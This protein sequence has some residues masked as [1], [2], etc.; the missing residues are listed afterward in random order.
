MSSTLSLAA[1]ST[2][3]FATAV[4]AYPGK[5]QDAHGS[6]DATDQHPTIFNRLVAPTESADA[7]S[8]QG[9]NCGVDGYPWLGADVQPI[10][11]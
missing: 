5:A 1:L 2:L 9:D 10:E 6:L 8:M 4:E 3:L 7:A 11:G